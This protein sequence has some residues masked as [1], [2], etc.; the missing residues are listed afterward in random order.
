MNVLFVDDEIDILN[1]IRRQLRKEN[2]NIVTTNSAENAL[3]LL[4]NEN[5]SIIISDERMPGKSGVDFLKE[6]KELYPDS[7]RIILSGYADSRTIINAINKGEIYRFIPKPWNIDDLKSTIYHALEKWKIED[8]NKNY[9]KEIIEENNRL[10]EELNYRESKLVLNKESLNQL[11][12]PVLLIGKEYQIEDYNN[13]FQ[14][15]IDSK[16]LIGSNV[17]KYLALDNTEII[18]GLLKFES[19]VNKISYNIKDRN[20]NIVGR[21]FRPSDDYLGILIFEVE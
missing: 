10:K 6:V 8:N 9:M 7:I 15:K 17:I 21:G 13:L 12:V 20:F 11:N 2:F 4:K 14:E 18:E 5:F 1:S 3:E 16:V 19:L